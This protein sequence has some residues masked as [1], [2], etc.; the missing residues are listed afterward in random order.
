[1]VKNIHFTA[2][3]NP[4]K[5]TE[6]PEPDAPADEP[7]PPIDEN[8]SESLPDAPADEPAPPAEDPEPDAPADEPAPPAEPPAEIENQLENMKR[9]LIRTAHY[10]PEHLY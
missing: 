8:V 5:F 9:F 1:M 7:A 4:A 10:K 2:T 6:D 3:G